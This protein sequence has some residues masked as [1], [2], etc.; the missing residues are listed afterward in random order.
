MKI[1]HFLCSAALLICAQFSAHAVI[2]L[3]ANVD[4][5]PYD[6]FMTPVKQ[7]FNGI[8]GEGATMERVQALMREGRGFRYSHTEP[9]Y[10]ADPQAT[11]TRRAGDCKDK[12]LW[13]M[14]QLQDQN[15]RFVIGKLSR[16]AAVSHAWL[17][18]E[19]E[20]QWW[21]LDCTM[22]SRPILAARAGANEYVPLY[23]YS[24]GAA[25]RH[26]GKAGLLADTASKGKT[27]V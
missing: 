4:H 25:Y 17:L 10:P 8:H 23:S 22:L 6:Q 3:G 7:V 11:A 15:V 14:D 12:A 2:D 1:K 16:G 18:W 21:I 5:T 20:G 27:G 13:L 26:T 19:H 24:H 9:Y